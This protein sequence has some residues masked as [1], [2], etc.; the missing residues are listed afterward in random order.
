[1]TSSS[2]SKHQNFEVFL[3]CFDSKFFKVV[4]YGKD[5]KN[6]STAITLPKFTSPVKYL[7]FFA[8][9]LELKILNYEFK[10]W[11]RLIESGQLDLKI[12]VINLIFFVQMLRIYGHELSN[13]IWVFCSF[14]R[15]DFCLWTEN[16]VP[17]VKYEN[18]SIFES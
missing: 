15:M 17:E 9:N 5:K 18:I 14:C 16:S 1:M 4:Q 3:F 11:L 7:R 2:K 6:L 10:I 12:Y 8:T 13:W